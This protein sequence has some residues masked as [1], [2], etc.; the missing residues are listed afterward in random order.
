MLA[1]LLWLVFLGPREAVH[2]V[3]QDPGERER[4]VAI[5]W[6]ESRLRAIGRHKVDARPRGW[7][8]PGLAIAR[9]VGSRAWARAVQHGLLLPDACPLHDRGEASRWSTR[10]AWGLVAAYSVPYLPGCWPPWVLDFPVV[11]AWVALARLRAAGRRGAPR[12]LRRWATAAPSR[13]RT[14]AA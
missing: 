2:L 14:S 7:R 6:R 12:A 11:S 1:L 10:G 13:P 4:L 5:G 9:A 3:T 8:G